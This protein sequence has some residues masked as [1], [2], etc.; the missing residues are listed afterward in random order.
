[1]IGRFDLGFEGVGVEKGEVSIFLWMGIMFWLI[2]LMV[3]MGIK[4]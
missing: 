3:G 4:D 2:G 1:M